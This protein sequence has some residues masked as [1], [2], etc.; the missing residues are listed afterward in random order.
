MGKTGSYSAGQVMLSKSLSHLTLA[1]LSLDM[2]YLFF[3]PRY[4]HPPIDGC[5]FDALAGGDECML[6][7]LNIILNPK[8]ISIYIYFSSTFLFYSFF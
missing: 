4:Q 8:L 3:F 7:Y 5:D 2:G 1:S 6:F